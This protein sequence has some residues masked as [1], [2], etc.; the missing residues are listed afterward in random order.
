MHIAV[1]SEGVMARHNFKSIIEFTP[2]EVME[3]IFKYMA[4]AGISL[5]SSVRVSRSWAILA[6][7]HRFGELVYTST[8]GPQGAVWQEGQFKPAMRTCEDLIAFL[9]TSTRVCALV[10]SLFLRGNHFQLELDVRCI[11]ELVRLLPHLHTLEIARCKMVRSPRRLEL[12]D[13]FAPSPLRKLQFGEFGDVG[14]TA[15][16][17]DAFAFVVACFKAITLLHLEDFDSDVAEPDGNWVLRLLF[18]TCVQKLDVGPNEWDDINNILPILGQIIDSAALME[19]NISAFNMQIATA[20]QQFL[21]THGKQLKRLHCGCFKLLS[22]THLDLTACINLEFLEVSVTMP[23]RE[24]HPEIYEHFATD[25]WPMT[26]RTLH[27]A[28]KTVKHMRLLI[29]LMDVDD[30]STVSDAIEVDDA[31]SEA[32]QALARLSALDWSL[33][34]RAIDAHPDLVKVEV[35]M[36][37]LVQFDEDDEAMEDFYDDVWTLVEDKCFGTE[38]RKKLLSVWFPGRDISRLQ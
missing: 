32:Q 15:S 22:E 37:L 28:P 36:R 31:G 29:E 14:F 25:Y 35:C 9:R 13:L 6:Y 34:D 16:T 12:V 1:A 4:R 3:R 7:P 27:N 2:L 20:A 30:L 24:V 21:Q 38:Q 11:P 10:E 26:L 19:L 33:L 8:T 23:S 5:S 18:G 17:V